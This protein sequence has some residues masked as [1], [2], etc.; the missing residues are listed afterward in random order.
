MAKAENMDIES[1]S[2]SNSRKERKG[3]GEENRVV[4][5]P[6]RIVSYT[7]LEGCRA[8]RREANKFKGRSGMGYKWNSFFA[9]ILSV[10]SGGEGGAVEI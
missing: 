2:N 7:M 6:Y 10:R 8:K 5:F 1:N 4:F 3:K 9:V